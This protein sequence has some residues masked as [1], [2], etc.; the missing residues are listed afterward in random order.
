M[1][2]ISNVNPGAKKLTVLSSENPLTRYFHK[3]FLNETH[4]TLYSSPF[5]LFDYS[6]L[7]SFSISLFKS[8]R[9]FRFVFFV[10]VVMIQFSACHSFGRHFL[11]F[12]QF[13]FPFANARQIENL[14]T[15]A[16]NFAEFEKQ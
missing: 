1:N 6:T 7:Q 10:P 12:S 13:F 5:G 8:S 15:F 16:L 3:I 2:K 9:F 14:R 4:L 11:N